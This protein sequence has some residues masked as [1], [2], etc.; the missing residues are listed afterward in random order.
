MKIFT[1]ALPVLILTLVILCVQHVSGQ[2]IIDPNDTVYTYNSGAT[3]GS[4]TNPNQP[5]ASTIGKWIK[6][7]R[8]SWNTS[9]WKCY[10]YNGMPFRVIFPKNY[11]TANDG[12]RYPVLVFWHGA[13]EAGAITDNEISMAHGG[14]T[15]FQANINSGN[16]P[17]FVIIPQNQNG[18]WDPSQITYMKQ[19][20]DY[21]ITNNK[22][23]P[24]HILSN[25]LSAGG[26]ACWVSLQMYPQ[27]FCATPIFSSNNQGNASSTNVAKTKFLPIWDFQG[28]L[29]KWPDPNDAGIVN[30]I[31]INVG[32]QYKYTLYS[33]LGH[34]TWDRGWAEPDFWPFCKH[35]SK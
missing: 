1:K 24:F 6:T 12:V 13:G 2:S 31:M 15:V 17:G 33:D 4:R 19:V 14:Q 22:V 26:A 8:M 32:A 20:L 7:T 3:K 9:Q 10:I 27:A 16:W 21:M 25:G 34:G 5:P 28:G 35:H 23:D 30:Q 29:D 18:A 11:T